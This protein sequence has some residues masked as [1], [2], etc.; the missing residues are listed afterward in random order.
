MKKRIAKVKVS[1]HYLEK[2]LK[3]EIDF[4]LVKS[5]APKDLKI[6]WVEMEKSSIVGATD[7]AVIHYMSE[8]NRV[9]MDG[10]EIPE[11]EILFVTKEPLLTNISHCMNDGEDDD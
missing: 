10:E 3:G 11:K 5:N 2:F 8:S 4:S 9:L 1:F 6:V 7:N